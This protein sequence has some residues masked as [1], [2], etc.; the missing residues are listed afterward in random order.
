M[1][2]IDQSGPLRVGASGKL[3]FYLEALAI[4]TSRLSR[5]ISISTFHGSIF[6]KIAV[7]NY[8]EVP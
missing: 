6:V 1:A 5:P 3:N 7:T 8:A 2:A 4:S